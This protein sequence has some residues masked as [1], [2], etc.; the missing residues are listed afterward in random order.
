MNVLTL[1]YQGNK[2]VSQ[3]ACNDVRDLEVLA[4]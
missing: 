1:L 3:F 4:P 2:I